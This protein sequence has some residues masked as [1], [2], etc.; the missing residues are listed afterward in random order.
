MVAS[1]RALVRPDRIAK[2]HKAF[3]GRAVGWLRFVGWL[4][5]PQ[6]VRHPHTA[7]VAAFVA[8]MRGNRGLSE[9]TISGRRIAVD[10]FFL[11]LTP[12]GIPLSSIGITDIDRAIAA[13]KSGATTAGYLE[14]LR[15]ASTHGA[16][17]GL[18]DAQPRVHYGL[19]W[20][21]TP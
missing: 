18:G 12:S 10:E 3:I 11:W 7:Q 20:T 6:R 21:L 15:T 8:W 5:E 17:E 9:E 14:N 1:R 2:A 13:K 16:T 4:D 19:V